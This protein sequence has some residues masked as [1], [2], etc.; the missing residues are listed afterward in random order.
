M[1]SKATEKRTFYSRHAHFGLT[2]SNEKTA[3]EN[4]NVVRVGGRQVEFK[5]L[6]DG[7]SWHVT[8]DPEEIAVL[9]RNPMVM[10]PEMYSDMTTPDSVKVQLVNEEKN[11]LIQDNNRL[12]AELD[13]IRA[14][15]VKTVPGQQAHTEK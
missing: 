10:T 6:G 13:K 7:F 3:M 11:R 15:A 2:I 9:E 1:E 4:G 5:A 12:Q 14:S 8:D